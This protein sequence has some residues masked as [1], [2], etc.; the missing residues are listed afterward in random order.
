MYLVED[1]KLS[2]YFLIEQ[3]VIIGKAL[4]ITINKVFFPI[5]E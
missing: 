5:L 4:S 3:L 1:S 2:S